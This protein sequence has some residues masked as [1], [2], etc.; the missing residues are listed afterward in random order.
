MKGLVT[1][2][3]QHAI[4]SIESAHE[5]AMPEI[6]ELPDK[7]QWKAIEESYGTD[8]ELKEPDAGTSGN[9]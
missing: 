5:S 3:E 9:R 4:Q 8:F 6:D 7:K 1:D 2:V